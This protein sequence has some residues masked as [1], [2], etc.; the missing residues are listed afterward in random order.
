MSDHSKCRASG[1][2]NSNRLFF[3]RQKRPPSAQRMVEE[4]V[5]GTKRRQRSAKEKHLQVEGAQSDEKIDQKDDHDC[6]PPANHVFTAKLVAQRDRCLRRQRDRVC[7]PIGEIDQPSG[8]EKQ[9]ADWK[10]E[11]SS[12]NASKEPLPDDGDDRG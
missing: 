3:H 4:K 6:N 5:K 8:E 7:E 2:K 11:L 1:K 10:I 12:K 9:E